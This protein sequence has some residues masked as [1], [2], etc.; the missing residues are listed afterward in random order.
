MVL[1]A[2]LLGGEAS[3]HPDMPRHHPLQASGLRRTAR[4]WDAAQ[5]PRTSHH[6]PPAI[7]VSCLG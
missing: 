7:T 1:V 6:H 2:A 3:N 4:H 5:L